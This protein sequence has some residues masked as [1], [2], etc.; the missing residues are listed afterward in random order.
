M[1]LILCI[2]FTII[3]SFCFTSTWIPFSVFSLSFYGEKKS[4]CF[5]LKKHL[6][7]KSL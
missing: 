6:P 2:G 7:S 5:P 3:V 4:Y 1:E